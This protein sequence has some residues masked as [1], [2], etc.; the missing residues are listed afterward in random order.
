MTW[1]TGWSYRKSHV[2][3]YAANA[4]TLYQKKITVHYGSGSDSGEDVYMN[5][6]CKTDFSDIRFTDDD[7]ETELDYWLKE[8][9]DS[10]NAVFWV[11]VADDLTSSNVT[12]YVYYGNASASST[13]NFD[14]TFPVLS[15]DFE[16]GTVG[17]IPADWSNITAGAGDSFLVANDQVQEGSQSAKQIEATDADRGKWG[18]GFNITSLCLYLQARY[19][20]LGRTYI[21]IAQVAASYIIFFGMIGTLNQFHYYDGSSW[22]VIPNWGAPVANTW[23]DIEI[24]IDYANSNIKFIENVNSWDSGWCSLNKLPNGGDIEIWGDNVSGRSMTCWYDLMYVRKYVN[25]EPAHGSWG[26]EETPTVTRGLR[27]LLMEEEWR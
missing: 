6:K 9:T 1:L 15:D 7:G 4:G 27:N 26:S 25:P 5:S 18:H 8:K 11:E 23:Y 13:S 12:I 2:I 14:N 19:A 22:N 3:E 16:D 21:H 24:Y 20:S 17:V 10:D